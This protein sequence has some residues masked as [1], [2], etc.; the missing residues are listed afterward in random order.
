MQI[1][2]SAAERISELDRQADQRAVNDE[3]EVRVVG[4]VA[5]VDVRR[6]CPVADVGGER[7]AVE[8]PRVAVDAGNL[9]GEQAA[10]AKAEAADVTFYESMLAGRELVAQPETDHRVG[11]V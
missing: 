6:Q 8:L 1:E 5:E 2:D 4:A 9:P 11:P 3:I 7:V 10:A